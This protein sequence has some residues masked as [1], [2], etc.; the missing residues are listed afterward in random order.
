MAKSKHHRK[1]EN[2]RSV[3]KQ[4]SL[5]GA[6]PGFF[7]LGDR[8]ECPLVRVYSFNQQEHNEHTFHTTES[9][10]KHLDSHPQLIH[11]VDVSG[12]GN[13]NFFDR[14]SARFG[15]HELEVEDV[16]SQHQRPKIEENA[17]HLFSISRMKYTNQQ[18]VFIDEQISIFV[19]EKLAISFQDYE[20]DCLQPV[21][22]RLKKPNSKLR[23]GDA[24]F[25]AYSLQDAIID[26][27][28][29]VIDNLADK[30][31]EL[32]DE[33]LNNPSK[34]LLN[35]LQD[36]KRLLIDLRKTIWPEKDKINELIRA[37]YLLVK[38]EHEI[39]LRDTY[40]HCVQIMDLIETNKEIAHSI[41]DVYLNSINNKLSEVMKVLT[42]IS[43][44]F[45]PLTFI[46][47]LYGM[48]FA[49]ADKNGKTLPWNMPE[50]Y[51]PWGYITVLLVMLGIAI[52][53]IIYFKRKKWL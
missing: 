4:M 44:V 41:M 33:V 6:E 46:A 43:S 39:Y 45:I 18:G 1:A 49:A 12:Y 19:F 52:A 32:E 2:K 27:Y 34:Y 14:M 31:T 8:E 17:G 28:F 40:D 3:V 29:P 37:R 5:P 13:K 21:R 53:Q 48:N 38:P 35:D 51:E 7:D 16:V 20:E 24:F 42:V 9:L 36:I 50:L 26:N 10:F 47:G 22:E 23:D 30:L 11:W 15:L 25:L